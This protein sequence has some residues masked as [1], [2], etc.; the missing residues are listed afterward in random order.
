MSAVRSSSSFE[1][2]SPRLKLLSVGDVIVVEIV[3]VE[4]C[5]L[6]SSAAET[7]ERRRRGGGIR[8][9]SSGSCGSGL[10][11]FVAVLARTI[12]GREIDGG[13]ER[14]VKMPLLSID[15]RLS[16][17]AK[18]SSSSASS[19]ISSGI[20][21]EPELYVLLSWENNWRSGEGSRED[22]FLKDWG[23]TSRV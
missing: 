12:G 14:G 2:S 16:W 8:G 4:K 20:T 19:A 11:V 23:E 6:G 10:E 3:E 1:S 5:D 21:S 22:V 18:L 7:A 15:T 9:K 13:G 17:L